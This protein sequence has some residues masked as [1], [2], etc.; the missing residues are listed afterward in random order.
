MFVMIGNSQRAKKKE[1]FPGRLEEGKGHVS[2]VSV[3]PRDNNGL[4][5][6]GTDTGIVEGWNLISGNSVI[7]FVC[8]M[9]SDCFG[10]RSA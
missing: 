7:S 5:A 1:L 6:I 2:A 4:V 3:S 8:R 10:G 9:L